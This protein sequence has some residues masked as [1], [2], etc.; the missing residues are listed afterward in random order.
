[1]RPV[2]AIDAQ[3]KAHEIAFAPMVFQVTR[4]MMRRGI[5]R[6]LEDAGD[7]G[8]TVEQ[9]SSR[10]HLSVY[11]VKVLCE[12]AL[13]AG[14]LCLDDDRYTLSKV[15]WFLAN[16]ESIRANVDF[17]HDVNYIGLFDLDRALTEGRPAGL[18]H[19]GSW[20]TVYEALSSLPKEVQ[21][22]WFEFDHYYSDHSFSEALDLVFSHPVRTLLDVGGNTGK[23]ARAVTA[24]NPDV[25][26]TVMDLPQQ[27]Q[28]MRRQCAGCVG[29]NRIDGYAA[30]LLDSSTAI[31]S[32][33][34]V[35]WMSQFLDCFSEEQVSSILS[36]TAQSMDS[37]SRLYIM[38]TLWDRQ[39]FPA[40][41]FDLA[42]TSVY[43][44]TIANG[45]SKMFNSRDLTRLIETSGMCITQV[46]DDLGIAG[47]SLII[48]QK[49][50]K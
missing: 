9:L 24:Y 48:C 14:S 21:D 1:M 22:S 27:L 50:V 49:K 43:F 31:P 16:D 47:H 38:E 34:D 28:M 12:S 36:R 37:D 11:A 45:N 23:F 20:P 46:V 18:S 5:F 26:V 42:Q 4:V 10:T 35:I 40:A 33:F 7:D 32:G 30:D 3:R 39:K 41:A 2:R 29:E 25:K 15:G 8:L 44:T 6:M 13:T 19:F 17:N